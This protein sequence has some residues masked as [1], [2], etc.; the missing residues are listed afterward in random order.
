MARLQMLMTVGSVKVNFYTCST[1]ELP[2]QSNIFDMRGLWGITINSER[3]ATLKCLK[4]S[5][6]S[7]NKK[8]AAF[9][10][11]KVI[12]LVSILLGKALLGSKLGG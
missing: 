5:N 3:E 1:F 11:R 10:G 4:D 12:I 8:L 2:L 6:K 9:L 7:Q